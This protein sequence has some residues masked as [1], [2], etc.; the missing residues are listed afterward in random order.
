MTTKYLPHPKRNWTGFDAGNPDHVAA[1]TQEKAGR[2][3]VQIM[4]GTERVAYLKNKEAAD[5]L[6]RAQE[7]A[8]AEQ[9]HRARALKARREAV[10]AYLA[11]R[12]E[13]DSAKQ[14]KMF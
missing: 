7:G 2:N 1:L 5:W 10:D 3:H 14:L 11:A 4:W 13:R 6:R 8:P 12:A 9:Y